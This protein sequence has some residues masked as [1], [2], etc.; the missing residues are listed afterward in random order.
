MSFLTINGVRLPVELESFDQ[1]ER[2]VASTVFAQSGVVRKSRAAL[3][4]D[5]SCSTIPIPQDEASIWQ[6]MIS[7]EG[8]AW[9]MTTFY[10]RKGSSVIV[11]GASLT[12]GYL[13]IPAAGSPGTGVLNYNFFPEALGWTIFVRRYT[14]DGGGAPVSPI[15][16]IVRSDG[17]K[18]VNGVRNDAAVTTWLT[19]TI[20]SATLSG[21]TGASP[22]NDIYYQNAWAFP[23]IIPQT[24]IEGG[25]Y[26]NMQFWGLFYSPRLRVE[27]DAI[28]R[29]G[30][31]NYRRCIGTV[32]RNTAVRGVMS[33]V[34]RRNLRRLDLKLSEA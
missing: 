16:Y 23:D 8:D 28:L 31:S 17:A 27:G 24:W 18:W 5:I 21:Q 3:K 30:P 13:K 32:N 4:V 15:N 14:D 12:G 10:T 19:A 1:Q 33:G 22:A 11:T 9:D 6:L 20:T 26:S 25:M 2:E 7:G 34:L 29:G